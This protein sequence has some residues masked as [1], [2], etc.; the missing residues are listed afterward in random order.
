MSDD[1]AL[2]TGGTNPDDGSGV[3]RS[4]AARW[5][6]LGTR[7]PGVFVAVAAITG[8]GLGMGARVWM[9]WISVDPEFSWTGTLAIV[10]GFT[11]FAAAQ[12]AAAVARIRSTRP[13]GIAGVRTAAAL[14]SGGLFGAAGAVM[15]PTVVFGSLAVWR[16]GM[17]RV[18]RVLLA[19]LAVP[20]IVF[21]AIGIADDN[22][23]SVETIAQLLVFAAIYV[24]VVA[25]TW[26][27][28][29]PHQEVWRPSRSTVGIVIGAVVGFLA[30]AL[31]LG[32]IQ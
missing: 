26:P 24:V 16:T 19:L 20:S 23:W 10:A 5:R 28:V 8:A 27:T 21:V 1:A 7:H 25:A 9:R 12:A 13:A 15:L 31:Y 4:A 11:V 29:A 2:E 17:R 3:S 22:G 32:G 18:V 6:W 14:L 30:L